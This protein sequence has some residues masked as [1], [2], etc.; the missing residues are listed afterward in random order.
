[1]P[2]AAC[3]QAQGNVTVLLPAG[4]LVGLMLRQA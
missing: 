3:L 1:M 2:H 4:N